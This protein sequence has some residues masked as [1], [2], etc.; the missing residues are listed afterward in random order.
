M[1][2]QALRELE[3]VLKEKFPCGIPRKEIGKAT[4]SIL[5][6]RT[7]ANNDC[8]QGTGIPGRFK[9]GRNMIYPVAG[10]IQHLK[11]K[12]SITN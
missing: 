4:G 11:S 10:V 8:S 3:R 7:C 6:P 2:E 9:I 1:N 12:M 5:H